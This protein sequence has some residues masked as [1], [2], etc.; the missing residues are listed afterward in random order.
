MLAADSVLSFIQFR[1][2]VIHEMADYFSTGVPFAT[3]RVAT[4][5]A[6][7]LLPVSWMS[8]TYFAGRG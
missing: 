6:S 2:C 8:D 1:D 3:D 5:S 7:V 4:H